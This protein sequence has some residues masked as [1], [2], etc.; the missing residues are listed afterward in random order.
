[1]KAL[2]FFLCFLFLA[3][4]SARAEASGELSLLA[5]NVGKGDSLLL[6]S[7]ENAYL[8][9]AGKKKAFDQ[10][11]SVLQRNGITHLNGV[12]LTH[13]DSDHTGGLKQLLASGLE[14]DQVY[15]SAYYNKETSKHPAVKALKKTDREVIFLSVGDSLP[16]GEGTLQVLGPLHH[17]QEKEN[18]NSLVLLA[19]GGGGTMLLTGDMEFPEEADLLEAG[20]L[21]PVDVL[22]IGNHGESDATSEALLEAVTPKIAVIST[23][24]SEEPDTP[25]LRV[26]RLLKSRNIQIL[27]TQDA[28]QGVLV[29]LRDGE[30]QW[31][32][33]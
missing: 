11:Y 10:L 17:D 21:T 14:I 13:T 20:V 31:E 12:I 28:D 32:L 24:T 16:L 2:L 18:N 30:L 19:S 33:R 25:A 5:I 8:I 27:Q 15:A 26:I 9:D 23:N 22:K 29:T 3:P 6:Q 1:M 4:F 7:G